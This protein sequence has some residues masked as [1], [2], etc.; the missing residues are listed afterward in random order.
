MD[1][2]LLTRAG[3][4]KIV[5]ELE[6]L[7][8]VERP[9]VVRELLEAAREGRLEKN[10]EFQWALAQRQRL[11]KR[12]RQLQQILA[13][14][15]V[16]VGSNLPPDQVRFNSRVR[17]V[18]LS[19]GQEQ[20]FILVSA[21]EADVGQGQLSIT[22]PLGRA[23]LGRSPGEIIQVQTPGGLRS[24]RILDIQMEET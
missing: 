8:R 18:N 11:E 9:L 15:Q 1:K 12:I 5:R 20:E 3:Y 24:Y 22:S 7:S 23:L 2:I 19:Y 4:Q 21:V 10:Q 17:I 14:S 16:L 13:N 6:T